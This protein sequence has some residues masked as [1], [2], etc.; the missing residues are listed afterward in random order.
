MSD[1]LSGHKLMLVEGTAWK[2]LA[3]LAACC[4]EA[5]A[6]RPQDEGMIQVWKLACSATLYKMQ[7]ECTG[8]N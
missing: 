3:L 2:R 1:V 4:Q 7:M 6:E 8:G 5:E